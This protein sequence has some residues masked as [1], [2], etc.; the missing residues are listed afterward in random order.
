MTTTFDRKRSDVITLG[1]SVLNKHGHFPNQEGSG[2]HFPGLV[3][4]EWNVPLNRELG[5]LYQL[6]SRARS[7]TT[8]ISVRK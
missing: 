4:Q 3:W 1:I 7:S 2:V 6:D 5:E 8:Y